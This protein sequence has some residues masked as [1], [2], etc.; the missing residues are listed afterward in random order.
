MGVSQIPCERVCHSN[1]THHTHGTEEQHNVF[2][3][4]K[5]NFIEALRAGEDGLV[6]RLENIILGLITRLGWINRFNGIFSRSVL[7]NI[8][9]SSNV[10]PGKFLG[11]VERLKLKVA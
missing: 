4:L 6:V 11:F 5:R 10:L 9:L 1:T 2:C 3:C 7:T 8:F